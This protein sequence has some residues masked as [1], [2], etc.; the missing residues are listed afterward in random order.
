MP[1]AKAGVAEITMITRA[2]FILISRLP[3]SRMPLF[4][5]RLCVGFLALWSAD[6]Q[7]EKTARSVAE[8]CWRSGHVKGALFCFRGY[9]MKPMPTKAFL[10]AS[11]TSRGSQTEAGNVHGTSQKRQAQDNV[12]DRCQNDFASEQLARHTRRSADAER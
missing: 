8:R 2:A 11:L 3:L 9:A 4:F 10:P 12:Q 7:N 1:W 6:E 5:T